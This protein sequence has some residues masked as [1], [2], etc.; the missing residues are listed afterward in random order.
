MVGEAVGGAEEEHGGGDGGGQDHG[1]VAGAGE[2]GLG[3]EAGALGGFVELEG[4]VAVHGDG[5]LLGLDDGVDA[6]AA[7]GSGG[8][9]FR[10]QVGDGGVAGFVLGVAD[11][12]R[13]ADGAGDDVDGAGLRW[14]CGRRW[15]RAGCSWRRSARLRRSIGR[16]RRGRR[17]RRD[18][19]VVPAWLAWPSKVSS[20]R[21]WPTMASTTAREESHLSRTGPCSMWTSTAAKVLGASGQ[22]VGMLAGSRPKLRM[23]S[24]T[25]MPSASVRA[26]CSGVSWPVVASEERKGK[27]KRTPSSSEKA[28]SSMWKGSGVAPSCSM[29]ARA[30]RT[31][32]GPSK[33]PALVTVSMWEKRTK[34]GASACA[35]RRV[36]RRLPASSVRAC[37][38]GLADPPLEQGVGVAGG[39]REEEAGGFV[40]DVGDAGELA[41]AGD[42]GGGAGGEGFGGVRHVE[43]ILVRDG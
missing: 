8:F 24:A 42:D 43:I 30:R 35:E 40:G 32:S 15:R 1:V 29:A 7:E 27:P 14:R 19:G 10:E 21:D 39:G 5:A 26:R 11:V 2:D 20:R 22:V 36:A 6:D 4:E 33:A 3:V 31:P 9:G 25:V 37:E 34:V 13:G 38:V 28:M 23:A 18:M 41:A 17:W 12:E 16:R